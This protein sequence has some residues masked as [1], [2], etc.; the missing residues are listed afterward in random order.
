MGHYCDLTL[1]HTIG[2]VEITPVLFASGFVGSLFIQ[3]VQ[4]SPWLSTPFPAV[5]TGLTSPLVDDPMANAVE[6]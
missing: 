3:L 5:R 2:S 6:T 1:V 4:T